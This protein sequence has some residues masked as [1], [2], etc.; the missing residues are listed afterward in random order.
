[1]SNVSTRP[2]KEHELLWSILP[3]GLEKDFEVESFEKGG[4]T[5]EI[6]LVEKNIP[7]SHV[8]AQ[9]RGR[10]IV[11]NVL[12]LKTVEDFTLRGRRTRIVLKRRYWQYEGIKEMYTRPLDVCFSGTTLTKELGSFLKGTH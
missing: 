12:S 7:P 4:E 1:M 11:N 5:F 6:V 9:Y 8:P 2:I 10:K 3:E